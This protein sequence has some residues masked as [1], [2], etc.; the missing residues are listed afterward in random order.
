LPA[1]V[2]SMCTF[3]TIFRGPTNA[4][5]PGAGG[6]SGWLAQQSSHRGRRVRRGAVKRRQARYKR[7][8]GGRAGAAAHMRGDLRARATPIDTILDF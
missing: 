3:R 5:V 4:T 6:R 2:P 1:G 8:A 7:G